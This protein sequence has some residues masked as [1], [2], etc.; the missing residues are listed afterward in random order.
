MGRHEFISYVR[1]DLP[2]VDRLAD[3]LRQNGIE[4][5]IDRDRI[6]PGER[7]HDAIREAIRAGDLFI[8]CFSASSAKSV[9]DFD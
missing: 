5:W 3:E 7:W 9:G 2:I 1:E 4:V 8:A 6:A